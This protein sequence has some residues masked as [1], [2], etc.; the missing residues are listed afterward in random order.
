MHQERAFSV[1]SPL[2]CSTAALGPPKEPRRLQIPGRGHST[3]SA[4]MARLE[5]LHQETGAAL[6]ALK[7][8]S[9]APDRLSKNVENL[10]GAV[11]VPVGIAGPLLI[12][13]EKVEGNYYAPLATVEGTLVTWVTRGASALALSGG[14]TVRVLSHRRMRSPC[15]VLPDVSQALAL[16]S[17]LE[18]HS[19]EIRAR[20][21]QVSRE[22]RLIEVEPL[23][24][25]RTVHVRMNFEPGEVV[26]QSLLIAATWHVCQWIFIA[27]EQQ[28]EIKIERFTLGNPDNDQ[29][30]G[31]GTFIRRRGV[32]VVAECRLR[33]DVLQQVLH[34][35]AATLC[36]SVLE[37]TNASTAVGMLGNACLARVIAGIFTATGQDIASVHESS[38]GLLQS[39][40][41]P[42]GD[43]YLSLL[44]P[45][46]QIGVA[47]GGTHLPRQHELLAMMGCEGH[48]K[49]TA[50]AEI[51]AGFCLAFE[52]A[53]AASIAS[54]ELALV[55]EQLGRNRAVCWLEAEELDADFFN[56]ARRAVDPDSQL[57][58]LAVN[59]RD[60]V[61]L[62]HSILTA[63]SALKFQRFL[64]VFPFQL[65][66]QEPGDGVPYAVETVVKVKPIDEEVMLMTIN[67]AGMC[68]PRLG[69]AFA[70][71]KHHLGF[72]G[73]HLR[74]L[75][76]YQQCDPRLTRHLP[77]LWGAVQDDSRET[78]TLILERLVK[79]ELLDAVDH[80]E[81]WQPCY[82][83]AVLR[84]LATIHS[85]WYGREQELLREPWLGPV[86]T[87]SDMV[88][89]SELWDAMAEHAAQTFPEWF[90]ALD[91]A[92]HREHIR[93]LATWWPE[94]E[95]LPRTLVHHDFTPRNLALRQRSGGL[96]LCV[97]DWELAT[98]HVPQHDLAEFLCFV[99]TPATEWEEF[100]HYVEVHRRALAVASGQ[101]IPVTT[102]QRGLELSL[103]DLLVSRFAGYCVANTFQQSDFMERVYRTLHRLLD[104]CETKHSPGWTVG[105]AQVVQSS[106]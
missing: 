48:G 103:R 65:E 70:R 62:G 33:P 67:L 37:A 95:A 106:S 54:G 23:V 14:V 52:L 73:C 17:W 46:L 31:L 11:E 41:E 53:A 78:Y 96:E 5:F 76:I 39:R 61:R 4:R 13:G 86:P 100:A 69:Q 35:D 21:E 87:A 18:A 80:P 101:E 83:E 74:E 34:T 58:V 20:A 68:G 84:D 32:R 56:T 91:L 92:R 51:I 6:R 66:V 22:V 7:H 90:T 55:H 63:L 19:T 102:W 2:P 85:V 49:V 72:T 45:S 38:A 105:R 93:S 29:Q 9:L 26:G 75:A 47:G 88:A 1:V 82:C 97:Y 12:H 3:E 16:A 94:L 44:L 77:A 104:L 59:R 25:G 40:I 36:E 10:I 27:L 99:L 98:L 57:Q 64:G 42:N 8:L 30:A 43:L 71:F 28:G 15:F 60:D 50:F 89:A 79:I 81:H 24:L